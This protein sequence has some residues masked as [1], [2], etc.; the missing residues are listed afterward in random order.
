MH[1]YGEK[2]E[3][4]KKRK[5]GEEPMQTHE[6]SKKKFREECQTNA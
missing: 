3:K 5:E 1:A 2:K 6:R 4:R